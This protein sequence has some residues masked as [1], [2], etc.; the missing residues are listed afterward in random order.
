MTLAA[1]REPPAADYVEVLFLESARV[2]H[3][4]RSH[5]K[6]RD[7]LNVLR[8]SAAGTT[9]EVQLASANSDAIANVRIP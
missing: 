9:V 2:Y 6:F 4:A 3:L 5:P 7:I 1:V 8:A